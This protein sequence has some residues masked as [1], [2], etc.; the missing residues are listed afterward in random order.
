MRDP[1][2]KSQSRYDEAIQRTALD[3]AKKL[4]LCLDGARILTTVSSTIALSV[5][6]H[7]FDRKDMKEE[8][9]QSWLGG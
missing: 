3:Y 5:D 6:S 8:S 9:I 4:T 7:R 1:K 2:Q